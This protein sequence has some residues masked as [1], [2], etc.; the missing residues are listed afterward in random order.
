MGMVV[1]A[2]LFRPDTIQRLIG[3]SRILCNPHFNHGLSMIKEG[4]SIFVGTAAIL[5]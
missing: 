3:L 1:S 4:H 2:N 5:V